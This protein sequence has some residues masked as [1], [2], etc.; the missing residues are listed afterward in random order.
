MLGF[1]SEMQRVHCLLVV[2]ERLSHSADDGSFGVAAE[3]GLEYA[4]HLTITIV[5]ES[6][7]IPLGKFVYDVGECEETPIDVASLTETEPISLRLVD[8]LATGQIDQVQL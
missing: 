6:L 2:G 8:T 7:S 1:L 4:R 3:G 5:D